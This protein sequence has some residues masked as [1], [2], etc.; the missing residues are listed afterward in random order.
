MGVCWLG[1]KVSY[2][3]VSF[4]CD[5]GVE[6]IDGLPEPLSGQPDCRIGRILYHL[7]KPSS[8]LHFTVWPNSKYVI[9]VPPPDCRLIRNQLQELHFQLPFNVGI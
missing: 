5:F 3:A 9:R 4:S 1:V 2:Q 7:E 6:E 8:S